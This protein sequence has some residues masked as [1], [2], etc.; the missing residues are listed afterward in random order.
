ME[1][2]EGRALL[3]TIYVNTFA[4]TQPVNPPPPV[5]VYRLGPANPVNTPFAGLS[6]YTPPVLP[7]QVS[8]R[9]AINF[10]NHDYL[11]D[12]I[13]LPSGNYPLSLGALEVYTHNKLTIVPQN[14]NVTIDGLLKSSVFKVDAGANVDLES[15]TIQHANGSGIVNYG[16]V[17]VN[18][19]TVSYN[20]TPQNGGGLL[21]GGTATVTSST[22]QKN[23]AV[24]N[25][26]G[27]YNT[28][29]LSI[30]GRTFQINQAYFG[31]GVCNDATGTA[32]ISGGVFDT[33]TAICGGGVFN[34][35]NMTVNNGTTFTWNHA[36]G[37]N[38]GDSN[39]G[40]GIANGYYVGDPNHPT[41]E[42]DDST[43]TS[44]TADQNGGGLSN[45]TG[46]MILV[47]DTITQ[48]HARQG[49]G[50]SNESGTLSIS[51]T[52][53]PAGIVP[54]T[55]A[56]NVASVAGG[57]IYSYSK[58]ALPL[59]VFLTAIFGNQAPTGYGIASYSGSYNSPPHDDFTWGS[60]DNTPKGF[61]FEFV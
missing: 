4:D 6:I 40:G 21:N 18:N 44:N 23:S 3:S 50:V 53:T 16:T 36:T 8:L 2:L 43:F 5:S 33:N 39:D 54:T 29:T 52:I 10:A 61:V 49:G 28:A 42:V 7:S 35:G 34:D 13:V 48:N 59:S 41:L 57:G 22:F 31:G 37:A 9:V 45:R 17:Q 46:N 20:Q 26:G 25:G 11:P 58:D 55:I 60:A 14:G 38:P 1:P 19:C 32:T 12:T 30:T 15:L 56:G 27:V 51:G 24:G 47:R